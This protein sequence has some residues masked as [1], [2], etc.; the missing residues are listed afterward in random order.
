MWVVRVLCVLGEYCLYVICL[1]IWVR[2][3][4]WDRRFV[5]FICGLIGT[6]YCSFHHLIHIIVLP[7]VGVLAP[8]IGL[9]HGFVT[10]LGYCLV[11][12]LTHLLV[13]GAIFRLLTHRA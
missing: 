9:E 2:D 12:A 7:A 4:D 1:F 13:I 8:A 5:G 6:G 10:R 11:G 3:K